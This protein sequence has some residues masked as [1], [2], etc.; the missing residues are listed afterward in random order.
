VFRC[1]VND[2]KLPKG[3]TAVTRGKVNPVLVSVVVTG[4]EEASAEA[5]AAADAKTAARADA[6][7]LPAKAPA[8]KK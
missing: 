6:K 8:A 2:I 3:V 1:T 4:A 7:L 5:A